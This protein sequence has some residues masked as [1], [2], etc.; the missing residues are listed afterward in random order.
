MNVKK[1][2]SPVKF[3]YSKI[4]PLGFIISTLPPPQPPP[5]FYAVYMTEM[6]WVFLQKHGY[7]YFFSFNW[8]Y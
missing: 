3:R 2:S 6:Q 5:F 7:H 8:L 4:N 1:Y